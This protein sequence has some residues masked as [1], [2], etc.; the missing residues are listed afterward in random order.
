[1]PAIHYTQA[2]DPKDIDFMAIAY[3]G[4]CKAVGLV[5]A[6]DPRA[7]IMAQKIIDAAQRGERDPARLREE[8]LAAL[9]TRVGCRNQP[10]CRLTDE[11]DRLLTHVDANA[12]GADSQCQL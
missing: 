5:D 4:A 7:V 1:M 10:E 2:F 12:R 3:E 11:S 6:K 8:A 9:A